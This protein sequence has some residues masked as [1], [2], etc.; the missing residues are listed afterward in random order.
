MGLKERRLVDDAKREHI[1]AYEA[2]ARAACGADVKM[3]IDWATFE[4]DATALEGLQSGLFTCCHA[5]ERVCKDDIGKSAVKERLKAFR[6]INVK[7]RAAIGFD[8][9]DGIVT[10]RLLDGGAASVGYAPDI[11]RVIEA[12][13]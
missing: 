3:E 9:T 5:L 12:A 11:A 8:C 10:A 4:D 13:L 7:D 1:P 6:I 2:K